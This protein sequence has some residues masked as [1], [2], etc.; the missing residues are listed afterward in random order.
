MPF[1]EYACGACKKQFEVL[2]KMS[3]APKQKCPKC[4]QKKLKRLISAAALHFKG[5]G[6]TTKGS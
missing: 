6:W 5:T 3:D 4:G 2:Q 1:Y